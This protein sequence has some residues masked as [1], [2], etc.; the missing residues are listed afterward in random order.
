M[1][2]SFPNLR[3]LLQR[4]DYTKIISAQLIVKPVPS[5]YNGLFALPPATGGRYP[6]M[7]LNEPGGVLTTTSAA[8]R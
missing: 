4:P 8:A 6:P 5:S 1:K 7:W 2:I 3:N